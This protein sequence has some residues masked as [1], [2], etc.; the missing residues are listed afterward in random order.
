MKQSRGE[1]AEAGARWMRRRGRQ[2]GHHAGNREI[3]V[4][5]CESQHHVRERMSW[6]EVSWAPVG[7]GGQ[8]LSHVWGPQGK[9]F[10]TRGCLRA[11]WWETYLVVRSRSPLSLV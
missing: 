9:N 2:W 3:H 10:L 4:E 11:S 8:A 5:E 6:A 1:E 7:H